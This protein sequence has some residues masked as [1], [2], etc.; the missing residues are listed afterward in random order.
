MSELDWRD[1]DSTSITAEAYDPDAEVIYVRF[2]SGAEYGYEACP[3]HVWEEFTSPG[4]SRGKYINEVLRFKP[5][6]RH[7]G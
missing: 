7:V 6:Q 4:Q 2:T 5:N 3:P 1:V